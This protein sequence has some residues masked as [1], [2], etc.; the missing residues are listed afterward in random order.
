MA[1][2]IVVLLIE[3]AIGTGL[4]QSMVVQAMLSS[5]VQFLA[6]EKVYSCEYAII[7]KYIHDGF[8]KVLFPISAKNQCPRMTLFVLHVKPILRKIRVNS[9]NSTS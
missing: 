5:E 9:N 4:N 8:S 6:F 3:G 2:T 7:P 1:G